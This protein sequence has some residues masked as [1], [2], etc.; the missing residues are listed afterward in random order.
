MGYSNTIPYSYFEFCSEIESTITVGTPIATL[1]IN[2]I[3]IPSL[4]YKPDYAYIDIFVQ[5]RENTHV[6]T[7]YLKL[8]SQVGIRDTG[9]TF[10]NG[11]NIL[12]QTLIM[13]GS[14]RYAVTTMLPG[15]RN[16]ASY[17]NSGDTITASLYA[18]AENASIDLFDVYGKLR[19]YFSIV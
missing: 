1:D 9:A 16:I 12:E 7:N 13:P 3:T 19:C 6:A 18:E 11:G 8:G 10:R 4:R 17:I 5:G 14:T 15:T 2:D